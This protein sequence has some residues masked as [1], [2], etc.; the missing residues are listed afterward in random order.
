MLILRPYIIQNWSS[1]IITSQSLNFFMQQVYLEAGLCRVF[2]KKYWIA[3]C[4][5][6]CLSIK[7]A[8]VFHCLQKN[9]SYFFFYF[10]DFFQLGLIQLYICLQ[11]EK[12]NSLWTQLF[13]IYKSFS[14]CKQKVERNSIVQMKVGFRTT[15][16]LDFNKNIWNISIFLF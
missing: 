3:T 13:F 4:V 12:L 8:L 15:F 11:C 9:T 16:P 6:V 10:K 2:L 5:R 14:T 1:W 7:Y